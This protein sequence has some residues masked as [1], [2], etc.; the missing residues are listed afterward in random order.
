MPHSPVRMRAPIDD[1]QAFEQEL[2]NI[3]E[4]LSPS[5]G[6]GDKGNNLNKAF[7]TLN[8]IKFLNIKVCNKI[9]AQEIF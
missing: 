6:Q 2:L 5:D 9:T 7:E 3:N 4:A 8:Q 1:M